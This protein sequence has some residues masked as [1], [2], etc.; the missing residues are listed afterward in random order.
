MAL[1]HMR[2]PEAMRHGLIHLA[3]VTATIRIICCCGSAL[4]DSA[5]GLLVKHTSEKPLSKLNQHTLNK[6]MRRSNCSINIQLWKV[7][8]DDGEDPED[9]D[10]GDGRGES[11]GVRMVRMEKVVM[12]SDDE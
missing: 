9:S 4:H 2:V 12:M 8:V 1:Q 3:T 11:D 10:E 5:T 7:M 6:V